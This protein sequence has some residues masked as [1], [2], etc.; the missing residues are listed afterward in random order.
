MFKILLVGCGGFIGSV[1]RYLVAMLTHYWIQRDDLP[2]ATLIVNVIGCLLIG[3]LARLGEVR[4]VLT[5]QSRAFI[6]VGILGGFTTYSSF[7]NETI[8]LGRN[9]QS[10]MAL[11]NVAAQLLLGLGAVWIGREICQKIWG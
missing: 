3:M 6:I 11:T 9:G 10:M 4:G 1:F 2:I 7:A 5:E 8:Q